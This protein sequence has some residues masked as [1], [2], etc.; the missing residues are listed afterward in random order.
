MPFACLLSSLGS[1]QLQNLLYKRK[2]RHSTS[3]EKQTARDFRTKGAVILG[4]PLP[5]DFW[6]MHFLYCHLPLAHY[7]DVGVHQ[8]L[9]ANG[10]VSGVAL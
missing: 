5:A 3:F 6:L 4:W 10:G 1:F 2:H 9:L 8:W 7:V